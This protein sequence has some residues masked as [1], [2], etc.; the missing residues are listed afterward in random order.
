MRAAH[1]HSFGAETH[2][3]ALALSVCMPQT[4]FGAID[5]FTLWE[6]ERK[7]ARLA[8]QKTFKYIY[9][10]ASAKSGCVSCKIVFYCCC[11]CVCVCRAMHILFGMCVRKKE[12]LKRIL[13]DSL[14]VYGKRKKNIYTRKEKKNNM[15]V[16]RLQKVKCI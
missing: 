11:L 14:A 3:P 7:G 4:N 13:C 8:Y 6:K 12:N 1:K 15:Q 5:M 10:I 9:C 2:I 16:L